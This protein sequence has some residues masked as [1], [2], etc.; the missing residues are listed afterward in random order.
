MVDKV[1][2][3][4]GFVK[5]THWF[6]HIEL[7]DLEEWLE[8]IGDVQIVLP[9]LLTMKGAEVKIITGDFDRLAYNCVAE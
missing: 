6:S 7:A 9:F 8:M 2:I 4:N 5:D 1:E 3:E